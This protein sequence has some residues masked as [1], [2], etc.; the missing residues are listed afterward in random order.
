[1]MCSP[2]MVLSSLSSRL[3]AALPRR[4]ALVLTLLP[5]AGC[6]P[7]GTRPAASASA[8]PARKAAGG[9]A[10]S[11]GS[12]LFAPERLEAI[13]R[14]YLGVPYRL[15]C[16]GEGRAPDADPVF[17]RAYADCQTLVE[18]VMAEALA[19]Q[20]GGLEAAGRVIRYH[21]AEVRLENRYHYC[22]PDWLVNPW[23][24]REVTAEV[25][26]AVLQ[27]LRRR[28]DRPGLLKRRGGD[29]SLS[30]TPAAAIETRYIPRTRIPRVASRIP[31]GSIAILVSSNPAVVAGHVGFLFRQG[32]TVM[33]RHASQRKKRVV[34][35]P[36]LDYVKTGPRSFIGLQVL[37]PD[38]TGLRRGA[39]AASSR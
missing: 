17:T 29:P 3:R 34:D 24:A 12:E 33:L 35:Q 9:A 13:S 39:N 26:G 5:L 31:H 16:L 37:L 18:Q 10:A 4:L 11:P 27:P 38:V 15:D 25:G 23:P 36:L 21:G 8:P 20:A 2:P 19:P 7:A 14:R 32:P 28:I 22:I 6:Y 30:P 1:M